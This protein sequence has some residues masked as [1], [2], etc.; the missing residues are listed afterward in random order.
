[1]NDP[2][3]F[4][5]YREMRLE[6]LGRQHEALLASL[7]AKDA[8]I[9]KL[10]EDIA[11]SQSRADRASKVAK[12]LHAMESRWERW[13]GDRERQ[14]RLEQQIARMKK[15][16]AD[17]RAQVLELQRNATKADWERHDLDT[18]AQEID[19]RE[20]L[21]ARTRSRWMHYLIIAWHDLHLWIYI[22]VGVYFIGGPLLR[23]LAYF[24]MGPLVTRGRALQF[25][26]ASPLFP[27]IIKST[28]ILE[29][30]LW[31]GEVLRVRRPL[32]KAA[33][34]DIDQTKRLLLNWRFPLTNFFAG[35]RGMIDLRNTH[36]RGERRASLA[37]NSTPETEFSLVQVPEGGSLVVKPRY[38][39][40]VV[41]PGESPLRWRTRWKLFH[42]HAWASGQF[43]F[44]EICGPC[45][46]VL[47]GPPP[48][49]VEVLP[50]REAGSRPAR[51]FHG[52][53]MVGFSPEIEYRRV[54]TGNFWRYIIGRNA[55]LEALFVGPGILV[56]HE[57][58]VNLP[59][60]GFTRRISRAW[61]GMLHAFGL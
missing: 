22:G 10:R 59:R 15:I 21:V 18:R 36:A 8:E 54:R 43:R 55:L 25:A 1:M 56:C 30:P 50:T 52:R 7:A 6:E 39:G 53:A 9:A 32:L 58:A 2:F 46:V 11:S 35:L 45:R 4:T 23:A 49:R 48:L 37:F 61:G 33:D 60:R 27:P 57:G 20:Q 41:Q 19:A 12:N 28:S 44:I 42:R 47:F 17:A 40:G 13:F 3:D 26:E 31:P 5:S 29:V 51:R 38:V 16:E 14:D 24:S 34:Q